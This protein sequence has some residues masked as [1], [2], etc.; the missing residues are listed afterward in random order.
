MAPEPASFDAPRLRRYLAEHVHG[1]DAVSL[2]IERLRGGQSNPTYLLET[3]E[4]RYVLRKKPDGPVLRSAH[5]IERE[6]RVIS[7]LQGTDVPVAPSLCL[8]EDSSVVGTP[9]Y[10]M[11]FVEGRIFWDPTLPG[12]GADERAELYD[13]VNRVVAALHRIDPTAVGLSDYG[14]PGAYVSR[15]V[16]RWSEQ[17]AASPLHHRSEAMDRLVRWLPENFPD[18]DSVCISHGDLRLD[19][20]IFHPTKPRVVAVLD[21]E[22]STLGDPLADFSYHMLT[23]YLSPSEFRGMRG[24]DLHALGIPAADVYLRR[25]CERVGR[26]PV[27]ESVWDHYL[28]FNLFRLAAILQGIAVR[29]EEGNAAGGDARETGA[30]FRPIAE[31]AWRLAQDRLGAR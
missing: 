23:W 8:C 17:Y 3:N 22:L 25:Y 24:A 21:W 2:T 5:A 18:S 20:L 15:Q 29:A 26:P 9:F 16:V 28:V 12:F 6:Y 19:N 7:A 1:F 4:G 13:D 11:G 31:L 30:K 14:R 10:V 27:A